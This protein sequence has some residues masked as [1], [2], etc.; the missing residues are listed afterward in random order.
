M[1]APAQD[2]RWHLIDALR[3]LALVNMIGM[4]LTYDVNVVF[5]RDPGW[6]LRPGVHIWQQYICW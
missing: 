4:H 3:G 2:R 1:S 5:G 6:Y